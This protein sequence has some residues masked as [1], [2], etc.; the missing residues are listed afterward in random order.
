MYLA[1]YSC[2]QSI[3]KFQIIQ[4]TIASFCMWRKLKSSHVNYD[5]KHLQICLLADKGREKAFNIGLILTDETKSTEK[6][7]STSS[8]KP[9]TFNPLPIP[10][11]VELINR[12][13]VWVFLNPFLAQTK[14][15]RS[16]NGCNTDKG[17]GIYE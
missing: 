14:G 8:H 4:T 12:P 11:K 15:A 1:I 16:E 6:N 17:K 9:E 7:L 13:S 2:D 5:F 3:S 10:W